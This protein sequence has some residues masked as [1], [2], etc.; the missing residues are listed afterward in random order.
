MMASVSSGDSPWKSRFGW[1]VTVLL[2]RHLGPVRELAGL[3][4]GGKMR[5]CT[6]RSF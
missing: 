6:A 3:T 4:G 2:N 5:L 1:V